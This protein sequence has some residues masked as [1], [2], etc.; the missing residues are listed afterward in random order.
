MSLGCEISSMIPVLVS[1]NEK[2][3]KWSPTHV[4]GTPV[5]AHWL[6]FA[7]SQCPGTPKRVDRPFGG[8]F[9]EPTDNCL[10]FSRSLVLLFLQAHRTLPFASGTY[11]GV[12]HAFGEYGPVAWWSVW[13][14]FIAYD[15]RLHHVEMA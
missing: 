3:P 9:L 4:L 10:N 5:A 2:N 13:N 1:P 15:H 11:P 14:I 6:H 8:C 7:C 12:R